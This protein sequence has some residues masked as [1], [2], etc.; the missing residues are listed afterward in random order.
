MLNKLKNQAV[1][2][3]SAHKRGLI[4]AVAAVLAGSMLL[5]G[6]MQYPRLGEQKK[7]IAELNS[8]IEYEE[9]RQKEVEDLE[10]KVNSDEYIKKIATEKLG[11]IPSN[12]KVF[13][14]VSGEQ[15]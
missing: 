5:R 14:D 8:R 15:Q 11:L 10:S 6:V 1:N 4:I 9:E 13:V 7:E 12:A 3:I 2:Y